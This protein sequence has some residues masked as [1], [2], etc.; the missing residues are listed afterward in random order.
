MILFSIYLF[1]LSSIFIFQSVLLKSDIHRIKSNDQTV[2]D[3]VAMEIGNLGE[4][5]QLRR[6]LYYK[7]TDDLQLSSYVHG[8][9]GE[10]L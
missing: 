1:K 6:A 9:E 3:M 4:N 10:M 7:G 5:M 8:P 2:A